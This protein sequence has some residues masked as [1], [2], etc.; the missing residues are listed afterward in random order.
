[1]WD[2]AAGCLVLSEAGGIVTDLWDKPLDFSTGRQLSRNTG[3]VAS[4][5]RALHDKALGA[6]QAAFRAERGDA[7]AGGDAPD[8][9]GLVAPPAKI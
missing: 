4:A 7:A 8:D 9:G 2:H 6:A 1:M 5:H 3:V